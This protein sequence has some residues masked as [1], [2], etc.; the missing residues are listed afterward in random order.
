[1]SKVLLS[2]LLNNMSLESK[3]HYSKKTC[4]KWHFLKA[5]FSVHIA[6][7][8]YLVKTFLDSYNL[9]DNDS[10]EIPGHSHFRVDHIYLRRIVEVVLLEKLISNIVSLRKCRGFD[11]RIKKHVRFLSLCRSPSWNQEETEMILENF[12]SSLNHLAQGNQCM[13]TVSVFFFIIFLT[14]N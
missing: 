2:V 8:I 7:V 13:I 5:I 4:W 10:L 3:H 1:M 12:Q 11:L 14:F 6:N 9:L